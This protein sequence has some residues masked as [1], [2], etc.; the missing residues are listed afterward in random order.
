M[1]MLPDESIPTP[2]KVD[3]TNVMSRALAF[4]LLD[5][6][7]RDPVAVLDALVA[8]GRIGASDVDVVASKG[9]IDG[10]ASAALKKRVAAP[11]TGLAYVERDDLRDAREAA[12][13]ALREAEQ[14][15]LDNADNL[16]R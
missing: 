6:P 13:A 14:A 5:D 2:D 12:N 16:N 3:N 8:D 1:T 4:S 10:K 9:W 15:A 7:Q 11:V